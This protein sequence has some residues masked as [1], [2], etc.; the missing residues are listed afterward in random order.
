M[1]ASNGDLGCEKLPM[2]VLFI[3]PFCLTLRS[4]CST[5]LSLLQLFGSCLL[6]FG[7]IGLASWKIA[8]LLLTLLDKL[9]LP[10]R[11]QLCLLVLHASHSF[12]PQVLTQEH[13]QV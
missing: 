3:F 9:C 11:Q 2:Q 12:T 10:L 13:A 7:F 4:R 5:D 6:G 1:K 8:G